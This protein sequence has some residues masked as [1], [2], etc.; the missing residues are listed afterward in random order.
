MDVSQL[1]ALLAEGEVDREDMW[2]RIVAYESKAHPFRFEFGLRQ[3]PVEPGILMIRGPRQYG[4]ST[5]LD[6]EL[7]NTILDFGKGT[8]AYLNGDA[9]Y[10]TEDFYRALVQLASSFAKN[11]KVR[12]IFIDEITAIPEWQRALKRAWDEGPLRNILVVTTGSKAHDLRKG[13]ERLPGRKGKLPQTEFVFL[14]ISYRQFYENCAEVFGDKTWIAYLLSGGVPLACNDICQFE[15]LPEYFIE[16]IRDWMIGELVSSG[17]SRLALGQI[18]T[19]LF[20]FAGT[21]VGFAKLA[22]EA[23]LAN[24]TVASGYIEQLSDLMCVVS[25]L[26]RDMSRNIALFRKPAKFAF[27][28]LAAAIA[29]SPFRLRHVHEFEALPAPEQAKLMEWMVA[30][31]LFRRAALHQPRW[32]ETIGF[33]QSAEH[34]ID[35]VVPETEEMIEVKLGKAGP[36]DFTWF[37]RIFPKRHLTVVCSTPFETDQVRGIT[38]HDFLL[39]GTGE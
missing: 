38:L 23:G 20:R 22:R 5:W 18:L 17:R 25:L 21:P 10:R 15:Q 7:R 39:E 3:L 32:E 33:W 27:V 37:P 9:I 35:F 34:E 12:R 11:A 13:K 2:P 31:E 14:P 4:K 6:L 29:F 24:N 19:T 30:Q 28:N 26:P 16:L 8:A 36:M 1:N